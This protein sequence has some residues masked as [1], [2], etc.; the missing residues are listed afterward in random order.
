M[1]FGLSFKTP[2]IQVF[3][4]ISVPSSLSILGGV[5]WAPRTPQICDAHALERHSLSI[6]PV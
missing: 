2:T 3:L 1:S 4:M 5:T 6:E